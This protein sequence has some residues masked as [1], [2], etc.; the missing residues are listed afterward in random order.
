MGNGIILGGSGDIGQ[1]VIKLFYEKSPNQFYYSSYNKN[2]VGYPQENV[3]E[4][5]YTFDSGISP[6]LINRWNKE[7]ID[8]VIF[9]IGKASSKSSILNTTSKEFIELYKINALILFQ[10]IQQLV[11]N[12][13]EPPKKYVIINSIAVYTQSK[14]SSAYSASKISLDCLARTFVKENSEYKFFSLYPSSVYSK[15]MRNIAEKKGYIDFEKYIDEQ[16]GGKIITGEEI[17]KAC[18][19]FISCPEKYSHKSKY[20]MEGGFFA[21]YF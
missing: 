20:N 1:A 14:K 2:P 6:Y 7:K 17:A 16:L 5:R 3:F 21:E 15:M 19:N 10:F 4:F 9:S 13:D 11:Q 8:Y 12:L 18:W